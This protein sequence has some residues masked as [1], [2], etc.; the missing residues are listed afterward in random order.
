MLSLHKHSSHPTPFFILFYF[1]NLK[2][3][4]SSTITALTEPMDIYSEW[5]DESKRVN[6]LCFFLTQILSL[7]LSL[8]L[9]LYI[10]IYMRLNSIKTWCKT[11]VLHNL[12][13][14]YHTS[15]LLK[16]QY[17]LPHLITSQ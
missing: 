3:A 16:I 10:Y 17:I 8:S 7:S 1:F 14:N 2:S 4:L 11:H 5:I 15:I 12:I 6:N 13:S 9:S